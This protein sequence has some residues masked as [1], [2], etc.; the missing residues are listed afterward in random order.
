[1]VKAWVQI[2]ALSC[3][4]LLF[5]QSQ[6]LSTPRKLRSFPA[7]RWPEARRSLPSSVDSQ[8]PDNYL[9]ADLHDGKG[10]HCVQLP[11]RPLERLRQGPLPPFPISSDFTDRIKTL[12]QFGIANFLPE[13]YKGA[14]KIVSLII[15]LFWPGG[16]Q[17][18]VW[19]Q[20]KEQVAAL[21]DQKI[22]QSRMETLTATL[23][24]IQISLRNFENARNI[25]RGQ[26]LNVLMVN[27]NVLNSHIQGTGSQVKDRKMMIPL[28]VATATLHLTVMRERLVNNI[29]YSPVGENNTAG[30][31]KDLEEAIG[32]WQDYFG[33]TYKDWYDWRYPLIQRKW[34]SKM[35]F[36][37][38]WECT[39]E[40]TD[41]LI[42]FR[43]AKRETLCNC[44]TCYETS[45]RNCYS[46]LINKVKVEMAKTMT[47]T[48]YLRNYLPGHEKSPANRTI[49]KDK[50]FSA[51]SAGPYQIKMERGGRLFP[52]KYV[53]DNAGVVT[54]LTVG[55]H[56]QSIYSLQATYESHNGNQA[57]GPP[58]GVTLTYDNLVAPEGNF[59]S[60]A[61]FSP[62]ANRLGIDAIKLA[63]S[64]GAE[65]KL[66]GNPNR[67]L[68]HADPGSAFSLKSV[69]YDSTKV[70]GSF[71]FDFEFKGYYFG[72]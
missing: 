14:G 62:T 45:A 7:Q 40:C 33:S 15:D 30:Y 42:G 44:K 4:L 23:N 25:S 56:K 69:A 12:L 52:N 19:D 54:K 58:S 63:F 2:G 67:P 41:S 17:P 50:E 28:A 55:S 48:F 16:S 60:G 31:T 24:G 3:V 29:I 8:C 1:M 21:V 9:W 49:Q 37:L 26:I 5:T 22:L 46:F 51:I 68:W 53:K 61:L 38:L 43:M 59:T 18:S 72:E 64:G 39:G 36:P 10:P 70:L 11:P 27:F 34:D 35:Y 66:V 47:P 6:G 71:A 20:V 57:G 65:S 13:P 32:W